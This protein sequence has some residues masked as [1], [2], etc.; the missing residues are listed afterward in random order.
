[1]DACRRYGYCCQFCAVGCSTIGSEKCRRVVM[2]DCQIMPTLDEFPM[3]KQISND[4]DPMNGIQPLLRVHLHSDE[5]ILVP[6][7]GYYTVRSVI[8]QA[9]KILE[10]E[11]VAQLFGLELIVMKDHDMIDDGVMEENEK[12]F[13]LLKKMQ[14][15]ESIFNNSSIFTKIE[16]R[17]NLRMKVMYR[18]FKEDELTLKLYTS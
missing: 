9:C 2:L 7:E 15:L 13:D 14:N 3:P 16:Y 4:D 6:V 5:I 1:M 17:F 10:L 11:P 8:D 12:I 18:L